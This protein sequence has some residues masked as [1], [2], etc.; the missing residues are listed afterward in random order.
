MA[1]RYEKYLRAG[2]PL[3]YGRRFAVTLR[4][5]TE[6]RAQWKANESQNGTRRKFVK[7][8]IAIRLHFQHG[9]Y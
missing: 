1:S 7:Q 2:L 6:I 8:V 5:Y 9:M 4:R 3:T